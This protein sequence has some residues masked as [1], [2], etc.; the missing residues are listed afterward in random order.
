[1]YQRA[2]FK[3]DIDDKVIQAGRFDNKSTQEEQEEFLRSILEADQEEENE[4]AGDMND[5]ELNAIISRTEEEGEIFHRMDMQRERDAV[6]NWRAAGNRGKPPAPLMQVEELPDCYRT[7][8]PFDLK[9]NEE[10]AV[11][12]GARKR[13]AVSYNDGLDDD[14]WA[15]AL[16][17][18]QDLQ[19]LT[20][21]T[22]K[23]RATNRLLKEASNRGTPVSD[24]DSR[25]RRGRKPKAKNTVPEY[26]TPTGG[27]RKRGQKSLSVTP[28][29]PDDD[30]DDDR[31]QKRRKTKS[32]SNDVPPAV[33]EKMKKA[34]TEC[35]KAVMACEAPDGRKRC[36]LFKDL[37]DKRDYPDY[38]NIISHP[39]AMAQIRKRANGPYYKTVQQYYDDWKL[40]FNNARTYNRSD[41]WVYDDANEMEKVFQA[42]FDRVTVGLPGATGGGSG[43]ASNS[44]VGD[45]SYDSA[46]TPMDEDERPPPPSRNRGRKQVISDEEY[47]T[48]S[49]D[50]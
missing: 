13:T 24:T 40:M 42:T 5:E 33:R 1:M 9:E 18:G 45:G 6:E 22:R 27:K 47:L 35:H 31:D 26:D 12:R 37:P 48:P 21:R 4:E 14:T 19:E 23:A 38:Y 43:S 16:E 34:F 50:D 2:R 20:D 15:M 39:I 30:E 44:I 28:S 8:E 11:G 49:D 10:A 7:D 32:G 3:L 41:S 17:D 25:G 29:V 46:L 36:D